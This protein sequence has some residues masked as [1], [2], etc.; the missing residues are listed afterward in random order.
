MT[1]FTLSFHTSAIT[2]I[3]GPTGATGAEPTGATGPTG[4]TGA[5]GAT[6]A[7]GTTGAT[8]MTIVGTFFDDIETDGY[9]GIRF[10]V[11]NRDDIDEIQAIP[12]GAFTG[13]S[14]MVTG[15]TADVLT[16][17]AGFTTIY[18]PTEITWASSSVHGPS[19]A[20]LSFRTIGPSGDL[21]L[22]QD[23]ANR[24]G[25][26]ATYW[27]L[28]ISGPDAGSVYGTVVGSTGNI[29]YLV[30]KKNVKN[31]FGLTFTDTVTSEGTIGSTWGTIST[32][33]VNHAEFYQV[34]G[35]PHTGT[36]SPF[37]IKTKD[38]NVHHIY[39]P[40]AL[41]EIT[42]D[43]PTNKAPIAYAPE[44]I[45]LSGTTAEYG[46]SVN[47]TLII[48]GGPGGISFSN[49]FYFNEDMK[50]T[51]GR[52]IINCL[53]YDKGNSWFCTVSGFGYN[54]PSDD[55]GTVSYGA[56]C[57]APPEGTGSCTEFVLES[58]CPYEF[59]E[60][61]LCTS[62]PCGA[63]PAV[64][65]CCI[66]TDDNG[67]PF[68]VDSMPDGSP[69]LQSFC[70]AF[71]GVFRTVP[72]DP[73]YPCQDPCDPD[74]G[75][76]GACCR[77]ADNDQFI[78]CS[79]L[80]SAFECSENPEGQYGIYQGDGTFCFDIDCC[81]SLDH[82]GACCC[83]DGE[84]VGGTNPTDCLSGTSCFTGSGV[85]M[86]HG[87]VCPDDGGDI[88]C[89]CN[90][91]PEDMGMCCC[92]DC[93]PV[94]ACYPSLG[95]GACKY[96]GGDWLQGGDCADPDD[97]DLP[98]IPTGA[99][100]H[101]PEGSITCS[102][103][104]EDQCN[105]D[106]GSYL[107]DDTICEG[108]CDE[109]AA[110][111]SW[112]GDCIDD[113]TY[114]DCF[115]IAG[116][117]SWSYGNMCVDD[118]KCPPPPTGACCYNID[119]SCAGSHHDYESCTNIPGWPP[120]SHTYQG[121][122]TCCGEDECD[123]HVDCS[124]ELYGG[125]CIYKGDGSEAE[126][127]SDLTEEDCAKLN[128][129][130]CQDPAP[131]IHREGWPSNKECWRCH[132]KGLLE[133]GIV[134][135]P[136][137]V[138]SCL[139]F[140]CPPHM[141]LCTPTG[142]WD[143]GGDV[144]KHPI[145]CKNYWL[146]WC[147]MDG[148]DFLGV[149][150]LPGW[151]C[152]G[153]KNMNDFYDYYLNFFIE[154]TNDQTCGAYCMGTPPYCYPD[155]D[156]A[157][158]EW[159]Y[160]VDNDNYDDWFRLHFGHASNNPGDW[161]FSQGDCI[162][163]H[164]GYN[165]FCQ[166]ACCGKPQ[167]GG[168]GTDAG[169][170]CDWNGGTGVPCPSAFWANRH[171]RA[172][173]CAEFGPVEGPGL[174]G[175][176]Y[177]PPEEG[178]GLKEGCENYCGRFSTGGCGGSEHN[179]ACWSAG[180]WPGPDFHECVDCHVCRECDGTGLANCDGDFGWPPPCDIWEEP[181][182]QGS[183]TG[184]CYDCPC[185]AG[186]CCNQGETPPCS[187]VVAETPVGVCCQVT[188]DVD[189]GVVPTCRTTT[190]EDCPGGDCI[191]AFPRG[192]WN[193]LGG[194]FVGCGDMQGED[195]GHPTCGGLYEEHHWRSQC[196]PWI[197]H[198][199]D[200]MGGVCDDFPIN[201]PPCD[202]EG[203]PLTA[204]GHCECPNPHD[205]AYQCDEEKCCGCDLPQRY[206]FNYCTYIWAHGEIIERRCYKS[207]DPSY[208]GGLAGGGISMGLMREIL[209]DFQD[210]YDEAWVEQ[211][212]PAPLMNAEG[213]GCDIEEGNLAKCYLRKPNPIPGYQ[214]CGGLDWPVAGPDETFMCSWGL[215]MSPQQACCIN[216]AMWLSNEQEGGV[217]H[218]ESPITIIDHGDISATIEGK[219]D[220]MSSF[221]K[222][223]IN[224]NAIFPGD[225]EREALSK[226]TSKLSREAKYMV[227]GRT[228]SRSLRHSND[229]HFHPVMPASKVRLSGIICSDTGCEKINDYNDYVLKYGLPEND[230]EFK[231]FVPAIPDS[232]YSFPDGDKEHFLKMLL[233]GS[234]GINRSMNFAEMSSLHGTSIEKFKLMALA[235]SVEKTLTG[236][237][238]ATKYPWF[239]VNK[240]TIQADK[241]YCHCNSTHDDYEIEIAA[242]RFLGE[243]NI[244]NPLG[245]GNC[246]EISG[247]KNTTHLIGTAL[248][249]SVSVGESCGRFNI[250]NLHNLESKPMSDSSITKSKSSGN[251][252]S[253]MT[254]MGVVIDCEEDYCK[255][256]LNGSWREKL[257][258]RDSY[259]ERK[260]SNETTVHTYKSSGTSEQKGELTT[261]NTCCPCVDCLLDA[262]C[263]HESGGCK[264]E[265]ADGSPVVN[266]DDPK[267]SCSGI[268]DSNKP[269][270]DPYWN[271]V[272][273]CK[274]ETCVSK[275]T[276]DTDCR[277]RKEHC[278]SC[279]PMQIKKDFFDDAKWS[280]RVEPKCCELKNYNW[281]S[282]CD[283]SMT[284]KELKRISKL[285][286]ECYY[287][288]YTRNGDCQC[289]GTC[290]GECDVV[291]TD[292]DEG[293][294]CYTCEELARMHNGGSEWC[295]NPSLTDEYADLVAE[296]WCE[297]SEE[298]QD[299]CED[300]GLCN[301]DRVIGNEEKLNPLRADEE[302]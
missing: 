203:D 104:T 202:A 260:P 129:P 84:C 101:G 79:D 120:G 209:G 114:D 130:C 143:P 300:E 232:V 125:C 38:G 222:S 133:C 109:I 285:V 193:P 26:G 137:S 289:A 83:S 166:I 153:A 184:N 59:F 56:C 246:L 94:P 110:C 118:Y 34:H 167:S 195:S 134:G 77:F 9:W 32:R 8:G 88:N 152:D 185:I 234:H 70:E 275:G 204:C 172:R 53:T 61:M 46:E 293:T 244:S 279:G 81:D 19:G 22:Y 280:C 155:D 99:C 286:A 257:S 179:S 297:L 229:P 226:V 199:S 198:H 65:S 290:T 40:F 149:D 117:D 238:P 31:A 108:Q 211:C 283:G 170:N 55:D 298:C 263:E 228:P 51:S 189:D 250:E 265:N 154:E 135:Q 66:N 86:G 12:R 271:E 295:N 71:G 196:F 266:P 36:T 188:Y 269:L 219:I 72:C 52:D 175:S 17:G 103:V 82:S 45:D 165:K 115:N 270:N 259:E 192:N 10:G 200:Q 1:G 25:T 272:V 164:E 39:A 218:Q 191:L 231:R 194:Q 224:E 7:T 197:V 4:P 187:T 142:E 75:E 221:I 138:V 23:D 30:D 41:S 174:I 16:S 183:A 176:Y 150:G 97:C 85:Y 123:N 151:Q 216:C 241:N 6:G 28:G 42:V 268:C 294:G 60:N 106:S 58:E 47:V 245:N 240:N 102:S 57:D 80:V 181:G 105:I 139:N 292:C 144:R 5:T 95:Q 91:N 37:T 127:R 237:N 282:F 131:D 173:C 141:T 235:Y 213:G 89:E 273:N 119:G 69:V 100:C 302:K 301:C 248:G 29:G 98:V 182:C 159:P 278:W 180:G 274:G 205:P 73:N 93:M 186:C 201:V 21:R 277:K 157:G 169:V 258:L 276:K 48:D 27:T 264:C 215:H 247:P 18:E 74:I 90:E 132:W 206:C 121:D 11:P 126:A 128:D 78:T 87:S 284:C 255:E 67:D 225:L 162:P 207:M 261:I 267:Q 96:L 253:C 288:R 220:N 64:G 14:G 256:V 3:T 43:Y 249:G 107:G 158:C 35:N 49:K 146:L 15:T 148:D 50:F 177:L 122:G 112:E 145:A 147:P 160:G 13:P 281:G 140:R 243:H 210:Q 233:V 111:C 161:E 68:C 63:E 20:T 242:V 116:G 212:G 44:W 239:P 2:G 208:Q 262:I 163:N 168:G 254:P 230:D 24:L 252:G 214:S 136:Q 296:A 217:I 92:P 227:G 299:C 223:H 251:I 113:L 156:G 33:Y 236:S 190:R 171:D 178:G 76:V 291:N 287:R 62:T 124:T 54:L